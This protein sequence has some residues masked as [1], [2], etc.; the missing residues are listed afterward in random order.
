MVITHYK[1]IG[2][3]SLLFVWFL[4]LNILTPPQ[5][6]DWN[7]ILSNRDS[8][9]NSID[10][11]LNWN[12]RLGEFIFSSFLSQLPDFVFDLL[13]SIVACS[14]VLLFFYVAFL[15]FPSN[16]FDFSIVAL[17]LLLLLLL[18][19]F[20]E[21]FLWG[22]GSLNYLWGFSLSLLFLIPY[23]KL[24]IKMGGGRC[25]IIFI[26]GFIIGMWHESTSSLLLASLVV[27][28]IALKFI[29][30]KSIPL[31]FY[32]GIIGLFIGFCVL[33]FSPGQNSRILNE[34]SKYDY[35]SIRDFLALGVRDGIARLSIVF[36]NTLNQNPLF[37][38]IFAFIIS[39]VYAFFNQIKS[40]ISCI[41]VLFVS[42]VLF[43]LILVEFPLLAYLIIF[44]MFVYIYIKSKD[45]RF[46]ICALC[47]SFYFL[48]ILSTFQLLNLPFRSRSLGVL[49][50]VV[51]ILILS[52]NYLINKKIQYATLVI[53]LSYF[54]YVCYSY[55][56]LNVKWNNLINIVNNAKDNYK[57][58]QE[59][60]YGKIMNVYDVEYMGYGI[61]LA[62]PKDEYSFSY[63]GF[64]QWWRLS[65]DINNDINQSYAFIFK[66]RSIHLE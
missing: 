21:V 30:K 5:G 54:S 6:D 24:N 16:L 7:Y 65:N 28:L 13:N 45:S 19:S 22:S 10:V 36:H 38:P 25:C 18:M 15:R 55:Y 44:A 1:K 9:L 52:K 14:F 32:L 26:C 8:M 40:R 39:F 34:A 59:I 29:Y 20:E 56:D 58:K 50:L 37:F 66:I 62:I 11:F 12:S 17:F 64:S 3:L 41:A 23:M 4:V 48:S 27:Y 46:L 57:G 31:W 33:F 63:K 43:L 53:S 42:F 60:I 35:L 2:F 47:L 49:L 51:T 61:D